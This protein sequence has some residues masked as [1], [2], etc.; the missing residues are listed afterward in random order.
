M[1][2]YTFAKGCKSGF[3]GPVQGLLWREQGV[4]VESLVRYARSHEGL[5][6]L[7]LLPSIA[8][9]EDDEVDVVPG[10]I[11]EEGGLHPS[12]GHAGL[13]NTFPKGLPGLLFPGLANGRHPRQRDGTL[14]NSG[15]S[16]A[17][18]LPE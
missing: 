14:R 3:K 7:L 2:F 15:F 11:V 4:R 6:G 5:F 8:V 17:E 12:V 16:G 13:T 1:R 18:R 10:Q 9:G